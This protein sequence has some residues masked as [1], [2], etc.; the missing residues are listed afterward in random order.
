MKVLEISY[1][2]SSI[3]IIRNNSL[4]LLVRVLSIEIERFNSFHGFE[5]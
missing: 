2:I 3:V 1:N 4:L 5:K